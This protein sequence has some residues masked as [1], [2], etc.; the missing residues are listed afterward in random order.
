M[1]CF[2]CGFVLTRAFIYNKIAHIRAYIAINDADYDVTEQPLFSNALHC[3]TP[4]TTS[5][6]H[7]TI[8][9]CP[10]IS[11]GLDHFQHFY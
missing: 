1:F 11:C 10:N 2:L 6:V 8:L 9:K 4:T 5:E 7:T 3:F